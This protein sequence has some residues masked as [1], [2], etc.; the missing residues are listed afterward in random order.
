MKSLFI[1]REDLSKLILDIEEA[2]GEVTEEQAKALQITREELQAKGLS[3]V[4]VIKK[5]E[6]DLELVKVYEEQLE[7]FKKRKENLIKR[8]KESLL[9]AVDQFGEIETDIF[10]IGTRK[11]KAVELLDVDKVPREYFTEKKTYQ[12]DKAKVKEAIENGKEV[13]GTILKENKNLS[14]K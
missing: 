12:L 14:I 10:K 6:S 3:Y 4:H 5:L 7:I 9:V 8:L 1:I 2:G 13:P 11:S